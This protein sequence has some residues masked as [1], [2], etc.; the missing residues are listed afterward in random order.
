MKNTLL[1]LTSGVLFLTSCNGNKSDKPEEEKEKITAVLPFIQG[2]VAQIDTSLFSIKK[3]EARDSLPGDTIDI[4]RSQFR[5][6]A[7]DF[8]DV[9]DL[10]LEKYKGQYEQSKTYD[11]DLKL[12]SLL[13]LSK[14][15][16][17]SDI[18]KQELIIDPVGGNG[19]K[20][21]T[22]YID[23]EWVN[24]DSSVT[25]KM[26]WEVDKYFQVLTLKQLPGKPETSHLLKVT[27]TDFTKTE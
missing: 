6:L 19:G 10:S 16:S 14:T 8:L 22:I 23:R 20:I 7:K 21:K 9:P 15:S 25:K 24:K 11:Q 2:Q 12:I 5:D 1:I 3:I 13:T 26:I 17:A 18:Q 27:W 4:H